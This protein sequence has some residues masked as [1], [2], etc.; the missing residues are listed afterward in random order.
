MSED[1]RLRTHVGRLVLKNPIVLG[2]SGLTRSRSGLEGQI[3]KGYSAIVTKTVTKAPRAGAPK[4]TVFWYDP[5]EKTLLSG[6]EALQNP[7][8]DKMAESIRQAL[9]L[10]ESMDCKIVASVCEQ[11]PEGMAWVAK[12]LQQA[13]AHAIEVNLACPAVGPHLGEEYTKLGQYWSEDPMR[14]VDAICAVKESVSIPVWPKV[15][16]ANLLKKGFLSKVDEKAKPDAYCFSG[17][18]IA[19]LVI[20]V[21]TGKPIIPGN[22]RLKWE[23]GMTSFPSVSGP[24]RT[25][26]ILYTAYVAKLTRTPILSLGGLHKGTHVV[27]ALMVGASAVGICT[28]VYRESGSCHRM[29]EELDQFFQSSTF[30]S[31]EELKGLALQHLPSPPILGAPGIS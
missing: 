22:V 7:G 14:A 17:G 24:S 8:C 23:K 10:A 6:A 11:S 29:L 31:V 26:S 1:S 5:E 3:K 15:S 27:E 13:G 12:Q 19:C 28:A 9:S 16:V 30:T 20:D 18:K 21:K 25:I 2:S 4:P